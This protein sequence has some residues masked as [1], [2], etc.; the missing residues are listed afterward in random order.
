MTIW[1]H[2]VGPSGRET[3]WVEQPT[4]AKLRLIF[5]IGLHMG[6]SLPRYVS[7]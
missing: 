6:T 4:G 5:E 1:E 3:F 7:S 2:S